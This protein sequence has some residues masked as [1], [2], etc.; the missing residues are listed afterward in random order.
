MKK[1]VKKEDR[2]D[3]EGCCKEVLMNQ[4]LMDQYRRLNKCQFAIEFRDQSPI[5]T[6]IDR[7]CNFNAKGH[8]S[9][10]QEWQDFFRWVLEYIWAPI[11]I[12]EWKI[13]V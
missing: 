2:V 1:K 8:V 12:K 9:T 11:K 4:E 13:K 7:A 3:F 5:E 6:M 10:R